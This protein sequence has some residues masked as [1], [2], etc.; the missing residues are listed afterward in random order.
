MA[1]YPFRI[2]IATKTGQNTAWMTSSFATDTDTIISASAMVDKINLL[3]SASYENGTSGSLLGASG[4]IFGNETD[5]GSDVNLHLSASFITHP[6]TGSVVFTDTE[7]TDNGGLDYYTFWGSKV[8]SVLGI[9]E[10]IPIYTENFKLSDDSSNPSNYLSGDVI[11]DGIAIKESFKMAPQGRMR[12]NLVWDHQFGEGFLQWVSGSASKLLFGYDNVAD[13][14]SLAAAT[15]ATF[16]I[17]GVDSLTAGSV[18]GGTIQGTTSITTSTLYG[19]GGGIFIG[20]DTPVIL[21]GTFGTTVAH[22]FLA[23]DVTIENGSGFFVDDYAR[24]DALRVGITSTDPGD[25]NLYVEDYIYAPGL[26]TG[27]DNRV[28]ILDSDNRLKTDEINSDVWDTG[29]NFLDGTNGTNNELAVFTD[30]NSVEGVTNLTYDNQTLRVGVGDS[31]PRLFLDSTSSG[32]AWTAQGA[33]F[34]L[35]ESAGG[36]ASLSM[37]YTGDGLGRIGMGD[38]TSGVPAYGEIK[39]TYNSDVI[40]I[41]DSKL[42][43]GA[44]A[45]D[46]LLTIYGGS[47]P[48]IHIINTAEDDAG[49]KFSDYQAISTQNFEMLFNSGNQDLRIRSDQ[50]D[51]IMYFEPEGYVTTPNQPGF[52]AYKSANTTGYGSSAATIVFNGE[53]WDS[54]ADYNHINGIFTA[55][56]AGRYLFTASLRLNTITATTDYIWCIFNTT[57]EKYYRNLK[58]YDDMG[59]ASTIDYWMWEGSI[60]AEMASGD[61][62]RIQVDGQ[63]SSFDVYGSSTTTTVTT[64]QG[65]L[66]G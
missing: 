53:L 54:N 11:A 46:E 65:Y 45:P 25:G 62:C 31:L 52:S 36:G 23:G 43:I 14:Y 60:I 58:R 41:P 59:S 57:N 50:L 48:K 30:S 5:K 13:T 40:Q 22:N 29:K 12:S 21:Y 6:N 1:N 17:S 8:C 51:N 15:A 18:L 47:N 26:G 63:N 10:G 55:P 24:I 19:S 61:T 66:L 32:D 56:T 38:I 42:S 49:I 34:S 2:N 9:P 3:P 37:T 64:F 27:V 39:F 16:N 44:V 28:V 4:F 33:H 7:T 35:G 20:K